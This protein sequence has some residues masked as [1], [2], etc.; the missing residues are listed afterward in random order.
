[1]QLGEVRSCRE[2]EEHNISERESML[3]WCVNVTRQ[4]LRSGVAFKQVRE[5]VCT[6][7]GNPDHSDALRCLWVWGGDVAEILGHLDSRICECVEIGVR[8]R[9]LDSDIARSEDVVCRDI[10]GDVSKE[11]RGTKVPVVMCMLCGWQ[12]SVEVMCVCV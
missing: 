11:W 12:G 10:P 4:G 7:V 3:R 2:Q 8:I 5:F 6:Y 9:G 1:M